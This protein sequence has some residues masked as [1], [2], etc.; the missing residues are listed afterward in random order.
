MSTIY[1]LV[2][3][4]S[5]P[6]GAGAITTQEFNSGLSCKMASEAYERAM[7]D[8]WKNYKSFCVQK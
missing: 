1:I 3:I 6:S 7:S 2:L 5:G 8:T 4:I